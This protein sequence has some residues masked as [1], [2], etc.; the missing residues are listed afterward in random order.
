M[1]NLQVQELVTADT[2][3]ANLIVVDPRRSTAAL[4][5]DIWL[6][7]KREPTLHSSS[8]GPTF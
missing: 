4:R 6:Q 2:K 5:A 1:H 3:G 7:I 8:R